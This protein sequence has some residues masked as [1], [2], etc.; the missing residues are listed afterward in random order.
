MARTFVARLVVLLVTV[1]IAACE[2][3]PSRPAT[4]PRPTT[5]V[6]AVFAWQ[7]ANRDGKLPRKTAAGS[8]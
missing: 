1:G 7:A 6:A 2:K 8:Q 5:T 3:T 4:G